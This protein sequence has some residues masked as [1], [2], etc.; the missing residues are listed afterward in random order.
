MSD[1]RYYKNQV[2][3]FKLKHR[4]LMHNT[5]FFNI[6]EKSNK[7]S[8][9]DIY[10]DLLKQYRRYRKVMKNL[11]EFVDEEADATRERAKEIKKDLE[12]HH[13]AI[14]REEV[15]QKKRSMK[16]EPVDDLNEFKNIFYDKTF[17]EE[18]IRIIQNANIQ[19]D[20]LEIFFNNHESKFS[21]IKETILNKINSTNLDALYLQVFFKTYDGKMHFQTYSLN[22][23]HGRSIV[24]NLLKNNESLDN[25]YYID[26]NQ[27]GLI[28]ISDSNNTE[29]IQMKITPRMLTGF[30]IINKLNENKKIINKV[31]CDNGGS[32]YIYKINE[33]YN[34]NKE[35]L[36]KLERYQIYNNLNNKAFD[37]NCL[38][39]A[40]IQTKLF[41][42]SEI[43]SMKTT[44]YTRYI[45]KKEL[46]EFGEK[47]QLA[48]NVVKYEES[49]NKWESIT[50]NKLIGS[51]Q[52]KHTIE[53]ALLNKHY[54]LN[55]DVEGINKYYLE[56]YDEINETCNNKTVEW[57][58][59]VYAQKIRK[60]K[61]VY[62]TDNKKAH[63]KSYDFVQII[64]SD[65]VSWSFDELCHLKN[66]LYEYVSKDI[67][68]INNYCDKD[69]QPFEEKES[70]KNKVEHLIY[71]ADTETDING[72]IHKAFCIVYS[73]ADEDKFVFKYG[74]N[75]LKEFLEDLPNNA[76]V[77][78]HNLA[79]DIRQFH[80][81]N[82]T[83]GIEKGTKIMNATINYKGKR[84]YFKDSLSIISMKLADF[85]QAFGL[86][87]G[88]KEMFPYHYYKLSNL[89][90]P[91]NIKEAGKLEIHWNQQ[92]FEENINTIPGCKLSETTFDKIKYVEFYCKQDVN[93]L[94]QGFKKFREMCLEALQIDVND[95]L[96]A[97]SL[98]N[99][100]FTRE[101]Y[102]KVPNYMKYSGVP[103]AFIQ[104]AV[105]GGRCMT[106]LNKRYKINEELADF[107]AVSLY[108]SAMARLYCVKGKPEVLQLEELNTEYLLN[109]TVSENEQP[110]LSKPIS[111]YVV[112]IRI[113]KINKH[114]NFPCIVY[115][116]IK[117]NTNRNDD[118]DCI[119][120]TAVVDNI[121]L[122][123]WIK[124]NGL[125]CEIIRGYKWCG[126]KSFLI[127]EVIQKLHKLRC[128]YKKTKNPL[129]LIIKLI[130]NSAY[131]KMIQKPI[132]T[133]KLFKKY[134]TMKKDKKTNEFIQEYPL[135]K[136]LIKNSAKV[137]SYCQVNNN[138]Y[139]IK[140]GKQIDNFYTN[141]LLGVQIL[142]MSKRI[143]N[144][145]M[146]T[147]EDLNI[148]IYYQD[149]DS[150]HIQRNRLN[151]LANEFKRRFGRE[152][153]GTDLGQFHND[154]DEVRD[155]YA[156]QSIFNGKKMYIDLL[157]NDK[158]EYGIH[159]RMKGVNLECVKI[160]A[161]ENNISIYDVYNKI[162]NGESITFDLLKATA[163]IKLNNNMTT[164]TIKEF[165]RTV[166]ATVNL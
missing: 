74:S 78:F 46:E 98:A 143:M 24:Y 66:N 59:K 113:K 33:K 164:K 162:F 58:M 125:E 124:F 161:N 108:P 115:K 2:E 155:G 52:P 131:G 105:Y 6:K 29:G 119:N 151:D 55:E 27:N 141:T 26:E 51:K 92:Q 76:L 133:E 117:T 53:L 130:M 134:Q 56:H 100:Y 28:D 101:I 160:Y 77:Y 156:Y 21:D 4:V 99:Q 128:E 139:K 107:D 42:E 153:I 97:P 62:E 47:Y 32:F 96:T 64:T 39:Y 109:H 91:G 15:R 154:F 93:I 145:V 70:R 94:K 122:E 61:K 49:K 57:R 10:D 65:K 45:S 50:R 88:V 22:N 41:N 3:E 142:S 87:T 20:G 38:V 146:V 116:D 81:F 111:C 89:M 17:L 5:N 40:M 144:E 140:V 60:G 25:E 54:I 85:P 75:C 120:R 44:C 152:L 37:V 67:K 138:L 132:T 11:E 36:S 135:N 48:F 18:N 126:Q 129:Q 86:Q 106:K 63:M 7:V 82:I 137:I 158:G 79:Y 147:A 19:K 13:E 80:E 149:T 148:N 136:Y 35:L 30:R 73:Q 72:E 118:V 16:T 43:E 14:R 157:K 163:G 34:S 69:F 71:F 150:M 68:N 112:E 104:K 159:Y 103:R 102:N 165:K 95:V 114:L 127:R 9:K 23:E 121:T 110:T 166:K 90:E 1:W 31:Y 8:W 123:D 12:E 84:I 83:Q